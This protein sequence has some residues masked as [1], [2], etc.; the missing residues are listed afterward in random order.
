MKISTN[1]Y[2]LVLSKAQSIHL[3]KKGKADFFSILEYILF[4]SIYTYNVYD[5]VLIFT[6]FTFESPNL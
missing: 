2:Q 5:V 4:M 3:K 6:P 1:N